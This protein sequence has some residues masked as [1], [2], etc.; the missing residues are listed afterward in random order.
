MEALGLL[1][2]LSG[3]R[4]RGS[5]RLSSQQSAAAYPGWRPDGL[6][7][8]VLSRDVDLDACLSVEYWRTS[9][10][11]VAGVHHPC[12]RVDDFVGRPVRRGWD[13]GR[14]GWRRVWSG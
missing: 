9:A 3:G 12:L 2:S 6:G 11:L 14:W 7:R 4:G 1:H 8:D 13:D 5:H 10:L